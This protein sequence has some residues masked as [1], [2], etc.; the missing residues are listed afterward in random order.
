MMIDT[1]A[2]MVGR[3]YSAFEGVVVIGMVFNGM[4]ELVVGCMYD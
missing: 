2:V 4:L 1:G 3:S